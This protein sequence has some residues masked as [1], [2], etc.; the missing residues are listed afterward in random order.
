M[1]LARFDPGLPFAAYP[2]RL[3]LPQRLLREVRDLGERFPE[4]LS[5]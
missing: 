1:R 3:E 5:G 4:L 2:G